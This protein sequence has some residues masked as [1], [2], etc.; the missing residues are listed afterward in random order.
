MLEAVAAVDEVVRVVGHSGQVLRVAVLEV[1]RAYAPYAAEYLAVQRERVRFAA[2][3]QPVANKVLVDEVR[4]AQTAGNR[5]TA[6]LHRVSS[7]ANGALKTK[8]GQICSE[9]RPSRL[10]S[11]VSTASVAPRQL[12]TVASSKTR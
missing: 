6:F 3:V 11:N 1:P 4:L 9:A 5:F 12:D 8:W 2:D 10:M 7:L